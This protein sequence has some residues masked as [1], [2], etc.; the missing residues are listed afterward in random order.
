MKQLSEFSEALL[1][2]LDAGPMTTNELRSAEP[3]RWSK[4]YA[5]LMK[6]YRKGLVDRLPKVNERIAGQSSI[7]WWRND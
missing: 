1:G 4:V 6:L 7:L 5:E 2:Y 3:G